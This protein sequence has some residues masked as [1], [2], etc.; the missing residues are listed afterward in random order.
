MKQKINIKKL[1]KI[2][3]L[4]NISSPLLDVYEAKSYLVNEEINENT[5]VH[6]AKV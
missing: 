4:Y 2:V 5:I 6:M 3:I 1:S